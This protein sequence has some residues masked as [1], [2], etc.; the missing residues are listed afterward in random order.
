MRRIQTGV[1][2]LAASWVLAGGA[3]LAAA[4]AQPA[5]W[6]ELKSDHFILRYQGKD[7]VFPGRA[8]RQ[9]EASYD[10][11]AQALG[12]SRRSEFW[13]WDN[14][15][16]VELYETKDAYQKQTAQA[17][18]S[19]GFAVPSQRKIVSYQG[20]NELIESI[21]P[22]EIAHLVFNDFLGPGNRT[23]PLWL[24]EGLAM[25]QERSKQ[26][27]FDQLVGKMVGE[28]KWIPFHEISGIQS[29]KNAPP[30]EAGAFYAQAQSMVR[31]LVAS[32]PS[33]FAGFSRDL[34]D[35]SPL[36]EA[37]RKNYPQDFPDAKNFEEK[38]LKSIS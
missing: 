10:A 23:A 28:K 8:L 37:L 16:V 15:C 6:N 32:G 31:F 5:D 12:Y 3:F 9:A 36:E 4:F 29:L 1:F 27:V 22:H 17:N 20:S 19:G 24:N 33:R 34:R 7:Q 25:A 11:V 21:L 35:E 14:R 2:I 30:A 18:W 26:P 38:W 13:T